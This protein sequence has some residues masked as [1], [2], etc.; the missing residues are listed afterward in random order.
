MLAIVHLAAVGQR[1][2]SGATAQ[3]RAFFQQPDLQARFSQRDGG[4][5]TRQSAAD[6]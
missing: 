6:Y 2:G 5:Q 4:R 1:V 3:M